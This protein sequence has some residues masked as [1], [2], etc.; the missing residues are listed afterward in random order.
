MIA[1]AGLPGSLRAASFNRRLLEAARALAPDDCRVD[2]LSLRGVPLYDGDVEAAEGI[3]P[4]VDALKQRIVGADGLLLVT[5]EYNHSL[6]GVMKNAID[7]LSRPPADIE[8]VFGG[9]PVGLIGATPG[10]GGTRFAQSGWL[11]VLHTL[12]MRLWCGRQI[13]VTGAHKL[14]DATGELIDED[15]RGRLSRYMEEF[16][17]FVAGS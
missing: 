11:P 9:R 7:W 13:Y 2:V 5:P 12:G 4:A 1:V 3:P 8:R 14:F 17:A 15:T 10:A 6:P 16:A